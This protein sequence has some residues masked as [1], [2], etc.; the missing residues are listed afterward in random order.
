MS[1]TIP[2]SEIMVVDDGS[3]DLTAEVA[4]K[5]GATVISRTDAGG[6]SVSRN[7]GVANTVSPVVAF[8]D[9]DDEW[10]PDHAE[11]LLAALGLV[12]VAFAGS[13]ASLF[14]LES[15]SI[16]AT[17]P[18]G[19]AIDLRDHLLASNPVIQSAVMIRREAF[20]TSGG[21]DETMRLS[22]DYDLWTRVA[23]V[24]SFS[25]VGV[26][27]VRRRIHRDQATGRFRPEL[28]RAWWLV[29]RRA[30]ARRLKTAGELE[31]LRVLQIL[32]S[33]GAA[34]VEWAVWTGDSAMLTLVREELKQADADLG[35]G[36]TLG[37]IGGE[38]VPARRL[39]QDVRCGSRSLLQ[40]LQGER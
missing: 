8:I 33:A 30:V 31:K 7:L 37:A 40:K 5:F 38:G 4:R 13:D 24:G 29:R 34:D 20:L 18:S 25:H 36:A 3:S 35:L 22:E 16:T 2:P 1:Q 39:A 32:K 26:P 6:P 11:R 19:A 27:T 12:G 9:A 15:G 23:E 21:Y 14:G 28:V 10:L 17:L